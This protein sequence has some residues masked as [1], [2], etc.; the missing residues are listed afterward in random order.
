MRDFVLWTY[1]ALKLNQLSGIWWKI[2]WVSDDTGTIYTWEK[3]IVFKSISSRNSWL[4][5]LNCLGYGSV[6]GGRRRSCKNGR[7]GS[8]SCQRKKPHWPDV[9]RGGPTASP[10]Y[11]H[12]SIHCKFL[13]ET[14]HLS[15]IQAASDSTTSQMFY[16]FLHL[17][18]KSEVCV[19]LRHV[20]DKVSKLHRNRKYLLSFWGILSSWS[21]SCWI[22]NPET[23]HSPSPELFMLATEPLTM[24]CMQ[25][26]EPRMSLWWWRCHHHFKKKIGQ[27]Y[28]NTCMSKVW[29]ITQLAPNDR[30][31]TT[32]ITYHITI[33]MN[34]LPEFWRYIILR[35]S[36]PF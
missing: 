23:I 32:S 12:Q 4:A 14:W 11:V 13:R 9:W 20:T 34:I 26:T 18:L 10:H 16:F 25:T 1:E 6:W 15:S 27:K 30:W 3:Q 7:S 35:K 31:L 22:S 28:K 8:L 33:K 29:F 17:N 5:L 19:K 24:E 21:S 2:L 36:F